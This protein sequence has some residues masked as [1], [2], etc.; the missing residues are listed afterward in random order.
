MSFIYADD[1]STFSCYGVRLGRLPNGRI[2]CYLQ[3]LYIALPCLLLILLED[4]D[5]PN[6][7]TSL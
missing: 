6:G 4:V 1:F 7:E 3:A 2:G 5:V